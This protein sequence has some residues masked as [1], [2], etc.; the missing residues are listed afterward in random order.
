MLDRVTII[1]ITDAV[2]A[3]PRTIQELAVLIDKNW[4]TAD[5]Y[6]GQITSQTGQI[7]T[8]T[9]RGG[10]RGALKIVYWNALEGA[11]GS[12][13]QEQLLAKITAGRR[14][15]D[16]SPFDIYQFVPENR[17][18]AFLQQTEVSTHPEIRYDTLLKNAQHQLLFFSGNMSWIEIGPNMI[19]ILEQLAKK[20]VRIK[21]LTRV[22]ITSR[23]NTE[24][25]LAINQRVGWDAV[26]VRH[27]EHPL[28]AIIVDDTLA[29]IKEVLSPQQ[30][31]ASELKKKTFIFYRISDPEWINWLQKV[32]WHIFS[33]SVDASTRLAALDSVSELTFEK[34]RKRKK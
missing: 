25:T 13:Y 7:A 12:A 1:K 6:V 9:F 24:A 15:E 26:E 17:R 14:K 34:G 10:T 8:R 30:Y 27:A 2:R 29:S 19:R 4:R 32:F 20:R 11:R 23:K 3:R 28:R 18:K 16:F 31:R 22:D 5:R 21:V 33:Q